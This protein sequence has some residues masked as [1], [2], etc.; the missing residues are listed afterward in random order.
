[1]TL[2]G[3]WGKPKE[4]NQFKLRNAPE[5]EGDRLLWEKTFWC[6]GDAWLTAVS[7]FKIF[8]TIGNDNGWS[9]TILRMPEMTLYAPV[10]LT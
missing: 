2:S 10:Y 8:Y 5:S 1:M 3:V 9:L 7:D 6:H 4:A